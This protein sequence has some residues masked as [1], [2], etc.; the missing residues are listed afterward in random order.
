M[1]TKV[2]EILLAT[3]V[4]MLC[5]GCG[6]AR[7]KV[8]AVSDAQPAVKEFRLPEPPPSL[9]GEAALEYVRE[10]LWENFDFADTVQLATLNR[11]QVMRAFLIYV[12]MIPRGQE[13][14]YMKALMQR[15]T[16][17]KPMFEYFFT[18]AERVLHDPNSPMRNDEL[19]IP[20][21]E[22]ALASGYWDEYE[23]LPYESDLRIAMQNRVGH[24][25][26]DFA[27]TTSDGKTRRMWSISAKYTLIFIS[28]PGCEM[29]RNVKEQIL[30]S[31]ILTPLI[32]SGTLRVLVVYPDEDLTLW[33]E[34]LADYPK[35]WINAYDKGC[36]LERENLYDLKAI[37]ALYL[38][39]EQ[40]R[41]LAKDCTDVSYI[42]N[43]IEKNDDL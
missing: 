43:L 17:S 20:T 6:G 41:V 16:S 32:A 10:H 25:A 29:C 40:K 12:N 30:F 8:Q 37:P 5:V 39:D 23:R 19:Y 22:V 26:N 31:P 42:E 28:N 4:V 1:A 3:F 15:A 27:Y 21:L 35:E 34:H 38:L 13:A 14:Q 24:R 9:Q 7:R 33:R 11:E 18:L 36:V 2:R